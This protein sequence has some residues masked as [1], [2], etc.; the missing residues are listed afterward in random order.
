MTHVYTKEHQTTGLQTAFQGP[1]PLVEQLSRSTVKIEVGIFKN[2]EK[3][4]EVRHLNDLKYAHPESLA[5]PAMRPAL[6]RKPT[7]LSDGQTLNGGSGPET[8]PSDNFLSIQESKQPVKAGN[9]IV[10]NS[11]ENNHET[12]NRNSQAPAS[13]LKSEL[14]MVTGAPPSPAFTRQSRST[15]NPSPKYVDAIWVASEQDL[16]DI[17][18]AISRRV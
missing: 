10:A 12:S 14:P 16:D 15:R 1:F 8:T 2:G 4:Y 7:S 17:N 3:R 13:L 6:G 9:S 5:A 18:R 11:A